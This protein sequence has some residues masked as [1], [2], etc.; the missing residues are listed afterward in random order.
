MVY[1]QITI[2]LV[3]IVEKNTE[4]EAF[5]LRVLLEEVVVSDKH[6]HSEELQTFH[7][8]PERLH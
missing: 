1:F 3:D 7:T 5:S 6:V 8:V 4:G 2:R